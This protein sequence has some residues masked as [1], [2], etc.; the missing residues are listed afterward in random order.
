LH[1]GIPEVNP[2]G[3]LFEDLAQLVKKSPALYG[4]QNYFAVKSA[5]F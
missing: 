4:Y 2:W 3:G 5:V 1:A